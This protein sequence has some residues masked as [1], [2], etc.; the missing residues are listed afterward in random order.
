M[1]TCGS[2]MSARAISSSL[3]CP[4]ERVP[5]KSPFFASSLNRWSRSIAF[6]TL[7]FSCARHMLGTSARKKLSPLCPW[8]PSSMF[9]RTVSRDSALVSWKV[10]TTPSRAT[11]WGESLP[12]D[13]PL[14]DQVPVLGW[15]KPVS[16]LHSVVFPAP[17]G[18]IRPVMPPRWISRWSTDTAVRPPKVRVT[19]STT[20]AASGWATPTSHGRS[21]NA[22]WACRRGAGLPVAAAAA[23]ISPV[24]SAPAACEPW[25]AGSAGI[26]HHLS[27]VTEDALGSEH[28]QQ[29]E[30]DPD[31]HEA[32]LRDVGGGEQRV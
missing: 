1:T 9:C 28:Q 25:A 32:D 24:S 12:R 3:R 2:L 30:P 8:A 29:H 26:E 4:P 18:P 11:W 15:S 10:R 27:S 23:P 31:H 5:A 13:R 16:R 14:N 22:A 7:A 17:L 6:S 20:T 21:F 19:P